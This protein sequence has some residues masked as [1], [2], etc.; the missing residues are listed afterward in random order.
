MGI[1]SYF[2]YLI[3]HHAGVLCKYINIIQRNI[4]FNRLYMDCNSILYDCYRQI[5]SDEPLESLK[6][7]LLDLTARQIENYIHQINPSDYVYIAFDG[8]APMAKMEQ[9]RTRRYKSWFDTTIAQKID[10]PKYE[11]DIKK[12]TCMFT[13]GTEFMNKLSLYMRNR[14]E[15]KEQKFRL[16]KIIVATPDEPGEGEHKLYTHMRTEKCKPNDTC[17]VYGLDADLLMLSLFHL[18]Y[19]P[20]LYVF[21]EAPQ[22]GP[23]K[24]EAN[25]PEEPLFLDIAKLGRSIATEMRCKSTDIHRMVD[26]VFMC[27]FLGNDFLP[28]FPALNIRT[29]GINALM[30]AYRLKIGNRPEQFLVSRSMKI[31]W[32]NLY[33]FVK[34]ISNHEYHYI[35]QEYATRRR[36]DQKPVDLQPKK[37]VKEKMDLFQNTPM[38]Y[39]KEENY[40]CPHES[41]WEERYYKMLFSTDTQIQDVCLN[42]LEG[43]EWVFQYYTKG[44]VDWNWKY[45]YHYPPLLKDLSPK[46]PI[47]ATSFLPKHIT[48]PVHPQTQLAY[49]LPPIHHHLLEPDIAKK[50]RTQYGQYYVGLPNEDGIPQLDFVWAFCRYFWECHVHLPEIPETVIKDINCSHN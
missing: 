18:S 39:R 37:T 9:Q 11:V 14:F 25:D 49:V 41:K 35:C 34:E 45:K 8:V 46:I 27:F 38:L 21:R 13:P 17:V 40:I 33:I 5:P 29:G 28:H 6:D 26:Y 20:N 48:R 1:P 15:N 10:P 31:Q 7:K 4:E 32:K 19:C 22:F 47:N 16:K 42:Y 2:S 36:W 12:T 23:F 43:L 30:D 24:K 44:I 50:L 3:H